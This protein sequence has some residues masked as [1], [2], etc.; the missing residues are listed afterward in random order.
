MHTK[1]N[2][3][4][5][6]LDGLMTSVPANEFLER[7]DQ[8]VDWQPLEKALQAMYPATTGRPPC[9]PLVLFKMSLLQHCYGLSDPQCEELVADRLSWRR[10]VGLSLSEAVPD[11]TTL[12]RFRARLIEHGLHQQLLQQ[13]N[14]QLEERGLI[15]KTCTLVDATLVQAARRAP[16]QESGPG[17][18]D[19]GYTR[20]A[21]Q[22]HYGYKAHV[23]VD[24]R[25][26]LIR[27]ASLSAANLVDDARLEAITLG[28]HRKIVADKAYWNAY[29]IAW[30]AQR[31]WT[32]GILR[33]ASRAHPLDE[34]AQRR[35]RQLSPIRA[36]IEK[37]FGWW[38][39]CTGYRRT[40]YV[41][42]D[43]N[44]LE[45]E[46]KCICWN[47]KRLANLTVI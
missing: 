11:E 30:L 1:T 2:P 15:L 8:A 22:I 5:G 34:A 33:R 19:A 31:G 20:R 45:L 46:F 35:N 3:Q 40:R 37:V 7:L 24:Q 36:G 10:F 14:A 32:N 4:L 28:E 17:D 26:T 18:G 38:K 23:A 12:V 13:I 9:A 29:R 41:G 16:G 6:L 44:R 42:H 39:R 25:H 21:G 47:L 27:Q 43:P